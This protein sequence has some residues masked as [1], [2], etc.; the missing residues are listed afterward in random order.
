LYKKDS[1]AK[2]GKVE[3]PYLPVERKAYTGKK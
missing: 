1:T 3:R 2:Q